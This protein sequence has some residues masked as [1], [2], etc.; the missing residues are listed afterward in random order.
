MD[1]FM[2]HGG[3]WCSLL[4]LMVQTPWAGPHVLVQVVGGWHCRTRGAVV[5][6]NSTTSMM[7]IVL[8]KE[9]VFAVSEIVQRFLLQSCPR[10]LG[11]LQQSFTLY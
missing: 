8:L 2:S 1:G 4:A 6:P 7:M 5:M 10:S 9:L 3:G 11:H